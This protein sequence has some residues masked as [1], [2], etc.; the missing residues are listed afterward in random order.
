[1]QW[2]RQSMQDGQRTGTSCASYTVCSVFSVHFKFTL[3]SAHVQGAEN[4]IAD[5][6]SCNRFKSLSS[7]IHQEPVVTPAPLRELV[8]D[9]RSDWT[10]QHWRERFSSFKKGLASSTPASYTSAVNRYLK[11]CSSQGIDPFPQSENPL[12]YFVSVLA[13]EGLQ[14][15]ALKCYQHCTTRR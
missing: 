2:C 11:F 15:Q 7:Q 10:S 9:K 14:H 6:F 8:L 1:M 13:K 3:S 5:V 4:S 12:R